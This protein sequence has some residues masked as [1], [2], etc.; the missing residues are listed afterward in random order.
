MTV[1]VGDEVRRDVALIELH[2]LREVEVD[3]ERLAVL[4][5]DDTLV[6]DA[7]HCLGNALADGGIGSRVR[8]NIRNLI[9]GVR[10]DIGGDFGDVLDDVGYGLFDTNLQLHGVRTCGHEP[11]PIVDHRL[12]EHGCRRGAVT[13]DVVGLVRNLF[14]EL[15]THVLVGVLE[16]DFFRNSDTIVGYRGRAP[17]LLQYNVAALGAECRLDGVGKL[18]YA[19]LEP[20][21]GF[22][23]ELQF[24]SSHLPSPPKQVRRVRRA[25]RE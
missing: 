7:L 3:A 10:I 22:L 21:S 16:L 1:G 17:L 6:T 20:T 25:R 13:G 4:N 15:G 5:G 8:C 14:G 24:F 23:A 19:Y 2:T 12:G 9:L 18:I 11:K